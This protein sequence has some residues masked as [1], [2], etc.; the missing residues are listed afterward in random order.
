MPRGLALVIAVCAAIAATAPGAA[1]EAGTRIAI[2]A[3]FSILRDLVA[4]VGGDR[5]EVTALVGPGGD[6][7]TWTPA[8][9]DVRRVGAARLLVVN[10]LGF[11]G[12]I[13]RLAAA[14]GTP[15]VVASRG[16]AP[17]PLTGH[18]GDAA[19]ANPDPHAW[20][21]VAGAAVYV[22]N[23]RD[24][25]AAAD[26][27]GRAVYEANAT[28]CAA[29]LASLDADIRRTLAAIPEGRRKAITTHDAFGY[30]GADYGIA[31]VAAQGV[32]T[33]TQPSA[34]DLAAIIRTIRSER[35]PALFFESAVDPRLIRRIAAETGA[36]IGGTLFADT[37][38]ADGPA[39]TYPGMMR[40]NAET[41]VE[42]LR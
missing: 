8:P 22:T 3:S 35:I 26:P 17:R 11:E 18:A 36:R 42:A 14:S 32:S 12:S 16:V 28:A 7:H 13:D 24:G 37:L 19:P 5:V 6:T 23:I 31:F 15:V 9:G 10:G 2:V 39:A 38:A 33:E 27:A 4:R 1:Q 21:S 20:Q 40:H 30:F 41:L 34:R 25:L 29:Q